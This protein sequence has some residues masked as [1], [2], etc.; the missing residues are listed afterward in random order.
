MVAMLW[1]W[2]SEPKREQASKALRDH[3]AWRLANPRP[4]RNGYGHYRIHGRELKRIENHRKTRCIHGHPFTEENT[5]VRP[6]DNAWVCRQCRR[7]QA[8]RYV[9]KVSL[10]PSH[11]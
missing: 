11:P 8:V 7:D 3:R 6:A 2:L 10:P 4:Q 1:P 9:R 5:Y